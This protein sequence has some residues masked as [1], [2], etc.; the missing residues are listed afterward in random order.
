MSLLGWQGQ[1]KLDEGF[2]KLDW[3]ESLGEFVEVCYKVCLQE[4]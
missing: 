3:T 2:C 4:P 1:K